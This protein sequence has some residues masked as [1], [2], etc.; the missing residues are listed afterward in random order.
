MTDTPK[1][2]HPPITMRRFT[3]DVS[4]EYVEMLPWEDIAGGGRLKRFTQIP[5]RAGDFYWDTQDGKRKLVVA[6]PRPNPE[7]D[8]VLTVWTIDH[9]NTSDASW[10]WDGNQ[11]APTLSPSLHA[12]GLWHGWITNGELREA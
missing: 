8:W 5:Q 1:Y 10:S 9:K 2:G 4:D 7:Q 12:V 11:N 6:V 3:P